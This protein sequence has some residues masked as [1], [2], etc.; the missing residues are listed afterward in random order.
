MTIDLILDLVRSVRHVNT[1]VRIGGAHLALRTLQGGEKP[2]MKKRGLRILE[3]D[4]NIPCQSEIR[5]LIN[6]A[7]NETGD[8]CC[9][10]KNLR[11][12]VGERCSSLD[13]SEVDFAYIVPEYFE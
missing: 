8:I 3:L 6:G 11:E 12:R 9:G 5:V 4:G 7:R 10:A 13:S 2:S 1:G